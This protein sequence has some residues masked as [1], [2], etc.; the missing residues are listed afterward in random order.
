MLRVLFVR[1]SAVWGFLSTNAL[2]TST[3]PASSS[4]PFNPKS[5]KRTIHNTLRR[6]WHSVQSM[7]TI[8]EQEQTL[9]QAY[10]PTNIDSL[11]KL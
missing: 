6:Y 7:H 1:A 10:L 3:Y 8:G 4:L 2:I 9:K 11:Q 5:H